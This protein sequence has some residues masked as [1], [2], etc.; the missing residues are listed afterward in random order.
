MEPSSIGSDP[1]FKSWINLQPDYYLKN[2]NFVKTVES[3]YQ[4]TF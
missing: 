2:K 4:K 1:L 3:M